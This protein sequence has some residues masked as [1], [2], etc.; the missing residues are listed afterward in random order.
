MLL[1]APNN[2]ES[3][4]VSSVKVLISN[5]SSK[6]QRQ[7]SYHEQHLGGPKTAAEFLPILANYYSVGKLEHLDSIIDVFSRYFVH[8]SSLIIPFSYS[9][10]MFPV[11]LLRNHLLL[12]GSR[13]NELIMNNYYDDTSSFN[14]D[15]FLESMAE[16]CTPKLKRLTLPKC[17]IRTWKNRT[18]NVITQRG[19]AALI[20]TVS[21][22]LEELNLSMCTFASVDLLLN[23]LSNLPKLKR[24]I[25][26]NVRVMYSNDEDTSKL[27][28]PTDLEELQ[29]LVVYNFIHNKCLPH[30]QCCELCYSRY[31]YCHQNLEWGRLVEHLPRLKTF[32]LVLSYLK[33]TKDSEK[34]LHSVNRGL[35]NRKWEPLEYLRI[36][37]HTSRK[38]NIVYGA[39]NVRRVSTDE[40]IAQISTVFEME[41]ERDGN[42][43]MP[44][45]LLDD[46]RTKFLFPQY[47]SFESISQ[48]F[49]VINCHLIP[50]YVNFHQ[51]F[52]M[53][54][55]FLQVVVV[56]KPEFGQK[57]GI[58]SS[59]VDNFLTA[60]LTPQ[61]ENQEIHPI[62]P[63]FSVYGATI[64]ISNF[65][66]VFKRVIHSI[67]ENSVC[68]Y[69][70]SNY[71]CEFLIGVVK[72]Y[73]SLEHWR[74]MRKVLGPDYESTTRSF[75]FFTEEPYDRS[76]LDF[77][78][79]LRE[80]DE[81]YE[82]LKVVSC[83]RK[84]ISSG[85]EEKRCLL[86]G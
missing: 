22:T 1:S 37:V 52:K 23:L 69:T 17:K 16:W 2:P 74:V 54:S 9:N 63:V 59:F 44:Y 34:W 18:S 28:V 79:K 53:C 27:P 6:Q 51:V 30:P 73:C 11:P 24:L 86:K 36:P 49:D 84:N 19:V 78:N 21:A 35:R 62:C 13:L 45:D 68:L 7:I 76:L 67:Q 75:Q 70:F 77:V 46:L 83:K 20:K 25:L 57:L 14:F 29:D 15:D 56:Y 85:Y 40:T 82:P 3:L 55:E 43:Y 4:I 61:N 60:I 31:S 64:S 8:G 58:T 32:H 80:F 66:R 65:E 72:S 48:M 47:E 12:H 5:F 39:Q 41:K 26:S 71:M 50:R 33:H 10:N 42:P 81:K 38:R